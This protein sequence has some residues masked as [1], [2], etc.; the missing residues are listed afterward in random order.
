MS[1]T[2]KRTLRE[3]QEVAP[4]LVWNQWPIPDDFGIS[5]SLDNLRLIIAGLALVF[6]SLYDFKG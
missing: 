6:L 3:W 2:V 5:A 1:K 4:G